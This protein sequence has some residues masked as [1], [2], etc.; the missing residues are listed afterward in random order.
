MRKLNN[1][2]YIYDMHIY[3]YVLILVNIISYINKLYTHTQRERLKPP[4]TPS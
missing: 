3:I 1:I 2:R 4:H